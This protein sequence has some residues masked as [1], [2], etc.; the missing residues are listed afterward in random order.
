MKEQIEHISNLP[1]LYKDLEIKHV[2]NMVYKY[3]KRDLTIMGRFTLSFDHATIAVLEAAR[4]GSQSVP[5]VFADSVSN[6]KIFVYVD[7]MSTMED[8][9][10]LVAPSAL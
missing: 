3:G 1:F 4:A 6:R 5:L 7:S 8:L 9:L 2:L 10:P